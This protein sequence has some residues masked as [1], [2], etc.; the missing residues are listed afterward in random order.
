MPSV[1]AIVS[2]AVFEKDAKGSKVGDVV[3]FEKYVSKNKG[4]SPVAGG[5]AIFLVTVRPPD[6]RLWLIGILESPTFDGESWNAPK[7]TTPIADITAL[8]GDIKFENGS[9]ISAKKGALG[10]SLQTPRVLAESDVALL[11]GGASGGAATSTKGHLNAHERQGPTPCLCRKCIGQAPE[12]VTIGELE[13]VRERAEAQGRFLWFWMPA[14][15][16]GD[17]ENIRRAVA[18]RLHAHA[19]DSVK[20][21]YEDLDTVFAGGDEDGE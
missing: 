1:L 17:R 21:A 19:R 7:N 18:S 12:R 10:M 9:G 6:E 2:K 20:R 14:Q 15:L 11:R 3:P 13:L 16:E 8:K 5:G 4:I